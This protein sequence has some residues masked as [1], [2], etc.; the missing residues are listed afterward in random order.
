MR[1][2]HVA[3]LPLLL[4]AACTG[5]GSSGDTGVGSIAEGLALLPDGGEEQTVVWGD[6]VEA[7]E[8][9]GVERPEDPSDAE[10]V[11]DY[12]L[13]VTAGQSDD[14]SGRPPVFAPTPQAAH[15]EQ[16][17]QIEEF[18]DDV[19]WSLLD[20]DRFV[21]RLTPPGIITVVEGAVEADDLTAALGEADD[22]V[23]QAGRPGAGAFALDADE[24]TAA[25]PLGESLWLGLDDGRLAVGR[26]PADVEAVR[27]A[28]SGD[29]ARPTL[30]D[31]EALLALAEVLDGAD[32]Y[33]AMLVRPGIPAD[34]F[35]VADPSADQ[36]TERCAAA[37]PEVTTAVGTGLA[38]DDGPVVLVALAHGSRDEAEA[39]A[40]ALEEAVTSGAR[41][42]SGEDWSELVELA[43]IEVT[44]E[45]RRVVL[46]ELR[47]RDPMAASM[48]SDLMVR[49]DPLITYC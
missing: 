9:A 35:D 14:A 17:V 47:P 43:G 21:E 28:L 19:G 48:W 33:A 36:V 6:L 26:D 38:E 31:D 23:W 18:V 25:R 44:G 11:A 39:N 45:D 20:V 24:I 3:P 41:V 15:A 2:A 40:Q 4:A 1:W 32:P 46:A 16:L 7:A 5:G 12:G 10:V 49:R 29:E 37:L 30:A 42:V 8:I 27:S 34:P 22:G 13:A